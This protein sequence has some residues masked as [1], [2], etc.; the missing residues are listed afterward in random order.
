MNLPISIILPNL[1]H[2]RFLPDRIQT[3][4]DQTFSDWECIV[5]DGYS[6][7][8]SWEYINEITCRDRRFRLYRE[9][10]Q[11]PYDAWN[12]G[13]SRAE[14]KYIYIA[15]S[16]DTMEPRCLEVMFNALE[17]YRQCQIAHCCLRVIDEKG[18]EHEDQWSQFPQNKYFGEL[19]NKK[20]IRYT[21][22]DVFMHCGW[23][24]VYISV[25]QIF[26]N[27]ALFNKIGTFRTDLGSVADYEWGL[28]AAFI[29]NLIHIPEYLATWRRYP[30]QL[31]GSGFIN[32]R[33]FRF[34]LLD[35]FEMAY[36]KVGNIKNQISDEDLYKLLYVYHRQALDGPLKRKYSLESLL[37]TIK[38]L[39]V[40]RHATID[41]ILDKITNQRIKKL[42]IDKH[43]R[44]LIGN[45]SKT[46]H[47]IEVLND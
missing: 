13:I 45:Y 29:A 21:P 1:N 17:N 16:D 5:I 25:T 9:P 44:T 23:S 39:R 31:T 46:G 32:T 28:R 19:I 36:R 15:T 20:H 10:R 3:I 42:D 37:F 30:D 34:Q 6:D 18:L 47:L 43:I 24:T 8:G 4:L 26:I 2:L 41:F 27:K 12:K 7:D 33:Q 35:M 38:Y 22:H 14:G 40:H 11:G